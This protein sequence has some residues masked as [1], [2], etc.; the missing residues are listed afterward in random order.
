MIVKESSEKMS[1]K[2]KNKMRVLL[3]WDENPERINFVVIENPT[4]RQ[5]ELLNMANGKYINSDDINEGMEYLSCALTPPE[6]CNDAEHA[7]KE[8]AGIWHDCIVDMKEGFIE[9][10]F[11]RVYHSGVCL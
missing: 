8:H 2:T 10:P 6:Y 3:E 7:D 9:G 1:K 4:E 5:L 11:D